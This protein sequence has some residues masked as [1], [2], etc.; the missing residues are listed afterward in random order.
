MSNRVRS[1]DRKLL[2]RAVKSVKRRRYGR[3]VKSIDRKAYSISDDS[4]Y[5]VSLF[6]DSYKKEEEEGEED[7]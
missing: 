2:G 3:A 6:D 4:P 7:E 1:Y 5:E